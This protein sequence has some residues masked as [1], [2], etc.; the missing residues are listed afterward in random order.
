[1]EDIFNN[2]YSINKEP[3]FNKLDK[4]KNNYI[5]QVIKGNIRIV[6]KLNE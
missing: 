6:N 3:L 4:D 5:S 2:K 1:M